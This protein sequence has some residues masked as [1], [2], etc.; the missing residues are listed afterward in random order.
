MARLQVLLLHLTDVLHAKMNVDSSCG[1][2]WPEV[3]HSILSDHSC[4][5]LF[6]MHIL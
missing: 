5:D 4:I 6:R 3:D 2:L 1:H